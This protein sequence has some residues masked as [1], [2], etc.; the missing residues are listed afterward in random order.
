MLARR[1]YRTVLTLTVLATCVAAASAQQRTWTDDTGK[2]SVEAEFVET[3]QDSVVLKKRSGSVITVP[4]ARLS[5]TDQR[6]LQSL[7]VEPDSRL[8]ADGALV[9]PSF[10]DAV[11]EVPPW[12][13]AKPPFDLAEFLKAP[14]AEENAAPLYLDALFEFEDLSFC[15]VPSRIEMGA[16]SG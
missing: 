5:E 2:F 7:P 15:Y 6:Y 11:T 9:Y 14:P 16:I 8:S 10:P 3:K 12:N 1:A 13:D 4:V